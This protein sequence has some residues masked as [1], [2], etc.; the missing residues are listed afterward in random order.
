MIQNHETGI[1]F[2]KMQIYS[3]DFISKAILIPVRVPLVLFWLQ[4]YMKHNSAC[5]C[6]STV[7]W[8][9]QYQLVMSIFWNLSHYSV[10]LDFGYVI[11]VI[12]VNALVCP[13]NTWL[14]HDSSS[15]S[16]STLAINGM[17]GNCPL[18]GTFR[19]WRKFCDF[20]FYKKKTILAKWFVK[21]CFQWLLGEQ[22][23]WFGTC[24]NRS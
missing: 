18:F 1:S 14:D 11:V 24:L 9:Y 12:K 3:N 16:S 17:F 15:S 10:L 6:R 13:L 19:H 20:Q 5:C 22:M 23:L 8:W 2:M 7:Q 21:N 4:V